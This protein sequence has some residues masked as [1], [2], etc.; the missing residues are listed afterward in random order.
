MK[1]A[2]RHPTRNLL[3]AGF[4]IDLAVVAS[5][6]YLHDF[7]WILILVFF[8]P[9]IGALSPRGFAWLGQR[10]GWGPN[11]WLRVDQTQR[12]QREWDRARRAAALS[13]DVTKRPRL[14]P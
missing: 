11:R 2:K 9:P 4:F 1:H 6:A 7:A 14:R 8:V 13:G 10:F 5:L 3:V 12:I